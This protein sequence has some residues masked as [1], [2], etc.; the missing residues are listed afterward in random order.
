MV[1]YMR[2]NKIRDQPAEITP[3]KARLIARLKADG[4][5]FSYGTNYWLKFDSKN[6]QI[7]DEFSR[8]IE[9]VY[10]LKTKEEFKRSGKNPSRILKHVY[11]RSKLAFDDMQK[12]GPFYSENWRV[13]VRIKES[14]REIKIEFLRIFAEDEGS[15]L[16]GDR[17][18]R[19]Y[20]I[21]EVGLG[22]LAELLKEFGI[23]TKMKIGYGLKRNVFG[24]IIRGKENLTKFRDT[25]G[26]ESE[27]KKKKLN[28]LISL[29]KH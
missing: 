9:E 1:T 7:L 8:D 17:E 11:V 13:P 16:I 22:Q 23:E 15:I 28:D 10:G 26:F 24:L 25:I 29:F 27:T 4:S 6:Q 21:N 18:V 19:I 3:A 14:S 12:Y 2:F 5:T 20:S